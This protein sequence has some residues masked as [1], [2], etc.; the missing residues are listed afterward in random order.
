MWQAPTPTPRRRN[1]PII[2]LVVVL[3]LLILGGLGTA[4]WLLQRSAKPLAGASDSPPRRRAPQRLGARA[5]EHA[6]TR[7]RAKGQ[8]VR[9]RWSTA[10]DTPDSESCPLRRRHLRGLK[11][12]DGRTT[13]RPTRVQVQQ[14]VR[15]TRSGIFFLRQ[16][17]GQ[18]RHRPVA[19][20]SMRH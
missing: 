15:S 10:D 7:A 14:G 20:G 19:F 13:A 12:V 9:Q 11:R 6:R 2:A 18:P 4:G 5:A 3:G 16:R 17:A 8:C 1:A